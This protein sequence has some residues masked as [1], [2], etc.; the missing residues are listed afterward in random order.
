MT[1]HKPITAAADGIEQ[2]KRLIRIE[3]DRGQSLAQRLA[4]RLHLLTW[5]TPLHRMRL[6]GRF[7]LKLLAVPD[8]PIFGDAEAGAQLLQRRIVWR[9]EV[10]P[11]SELD[12][13]RLDGSTGLKTYLHSFA[14]LRDLSS[15]ATR[16][17]AAPVAEAIMRKWL[18]VHGEAVGGPAWSCDLWGQRILYWT[19]HAPLILSSRD[20]V[21]R[22]AVLNGLARGAR[23]IE[24]SADRVPAGL[25][26][27]A[28]WAGVIAAGLLI[29]GGDPRRIFGEAGLAR[30]IATGF[31]DEGGTICRS[32]A[33][34][35]DAVALLALLRAAY[36]VRR[37]PVLPLIETTLAR[38]VAALQGVTMGDGALA[39][40]Q[41]GL[42]V[43]A[44]RVAAVIEGSG[45]RARP[46]RQAREWG[47]QRL[48]G[49]ATIVTVDAAPPPVQ[50]LA[51]GGCA[52]TLAFEMSDAGHRLIVS[53]GGAR[54]NGATL[55]D[56]LAAA[57]RTTAAHSTLV[58]RDSNS[59]AIHADGS[60]GRGVGAV[61]I[62]R[63][64]V[65][66]GSRLEAS[67]DGYVRRFGLSHRRLLALSVDG[68]EL[69]GEDML[70]PAGRRRSH[71]APFA[72]RFHLGPA[73]EATLTADGQGALLRIDGGPLWQMRVKSAALA[74]EES[75]WVDGGGRAHPTQQLVATAE[76]PAG[77]AS[78]TWLLKRAG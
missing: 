5:R 43:P 65:E 39:S 53:C 33:Q 26:R 32:P 67:H 6:K 28:A 60:L 58:L 51:R 54:H 47:Y 69:R 74:I 73:V 12:F 61:E 8:D 4:N 64:E 11:L 15:A 62:E 22:S 59:T 49:G 44:A 2:G 71:A 42:P 37:Q 1:E 55:P 19:A 3:E 36:D 10:I 76:A 38:A 52:S 23:H 45:V 78:V 16:E 48:A 20:L 57:L 17:Q 34:L 27:V 72:I 46:L 63:Q 25:G 68:R 14:W 50:R 35:L 7:P 41:G 70:I 18:D 24:Q 66:S 29:P 21:Y 77:G 9:N 30:A 31:F 56:A 40:W 13:A 75:L